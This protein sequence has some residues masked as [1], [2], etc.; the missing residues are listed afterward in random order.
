MNKLEVLEGMT[1]VR[2]GGLDGGKAD[3]N[4][5]G[6]EFY[7]KGRV[8]FANEIKGAKQEQMFG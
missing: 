1:I 5:V 8:S 7:V 3:L 6:V 4:D 2:A